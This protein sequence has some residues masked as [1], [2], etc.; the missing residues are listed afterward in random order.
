[1]CAATRASG[2]AFI[3][4]P[5]IRPARSG[6]GCD[7][8]RRDYMTNV[9]KTLA[10][11]AVLAS[12]TTFAVAA[13]A[14]SNVGQLPEGVRSDVTEVHHR[15]SRASGSCQRD[16]RGWHRYNRDGER[17]SCRRWDGRGDRPEFCVRV[18]PAWLCDY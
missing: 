5:M 18:G 11:A 6:S 4:E 12:V 9:L 1:M 7:F 2:L 13:P 10:A 14:P 16:R 17:R 15:R 3:L 8:R